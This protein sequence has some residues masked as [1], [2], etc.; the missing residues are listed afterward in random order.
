GRIVFQRGSQLA[1]AEIQAALEIDVN[2]VTPERLTDFFARDEIARPGD[3]QR[4]QPRGL[5]LQSQAAAVAPQLAA[6][7]VELERPEPNVPSIAVGARVNAPSSSAP[8]PM[9][10]SPPSTSVALDTVPESFRTTGM[11]AIMPRPTMA[12]TTPNTSA[13]ACTHSRT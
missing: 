2:T 7:G 9:P 6:R 12:L 3:E 1:D 5:A 10:A 13:P 8:R 11:P 4:E